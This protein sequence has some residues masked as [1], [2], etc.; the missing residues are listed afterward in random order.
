MSSVRGVPSVNPDW[1]PSWRSQRAGGRALNCHSG[2]D[3]VFH[4]P[5][6]TMLRESPRR[7]AAGR[8]RG[9]LGQRHAPGHQLV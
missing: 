2:L 7:G 3:L 5:Y 9:D 4:A 1:Q 8:R 6:M